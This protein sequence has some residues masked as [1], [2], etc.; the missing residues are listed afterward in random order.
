MKTVRKYIVRENHK[1]MTL[2]SFLLSHGLSKNVITKLKKNPEGLLVNGQRRHTNYLLNPGDEVVISLEESSD[3]WW[4]MPTEMPLDIIYEDSDL[5]IVNKQPYLQVHPTRNNTDVSLANGIAW[6]LAQ[7]NENTVFHCVNRLDKNTS[8]LTMVVKN[9]I[10]AGE[11]SELVAQRK[12]QR[13]YLALVRGKPPESGIIEAPI[14]RIGEDMH[15][16]ITPDGKPSVSHYRNVA[17]FPERNASL[18]RL[19]L[20]TGRTHQIRVHMAHI[21][22]PLIGDTL[23]NDEPADFPRQGLQ[24]YHLCYHHPDSGTLMNF[25]LPLDR[26]IAEYLDADPYITYSLKNVEW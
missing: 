10:A 13:E 6:Y 1:E 23:Y 15:R 20:D 3:S 11:Y 16:I 9:Q 21:G 17:W 8:G 25:T 18:V 12:I 2:G 22:Y 26:E 19:K 24:A 4:L 5:L 14:G 7:R